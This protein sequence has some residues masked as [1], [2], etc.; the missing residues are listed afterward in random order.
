MAGEKRPWEAFRRPG[1]EKLTVPQM[2]VY[3]ILRG[4]AES[5][6]NLLALAFY[7]HEITYRA[8]WV[9]VCRMA[10]AL[11]TLGLQPDD[12]VMLMLPNSPAY[13]VAYYGILR[14][15]G[16][17]TQVN[18]LYVERELQYIA[19]D[20]QA[21]FLIVA[22]ALYDRV[23]R[24]PESTAIEQVIVAE[25]SGAQTDARALRLR[26]LLEASPEV[27]PPSQRTP[28]DTAVLQYTGGTTGLPKGAMLTHRNLVANAWQS[29][30]EA[31]QPG[32]SRVLAIL[33]FFHVF[34]MLVLN[35]SV[36]H[37][38][39]IVLL[40]RFEID[41]V[42]DAIRDHQITDFPGVPTMYVAVLNYPNAE[43]YG[44]G[45]IRSLSAGGAAMP[46]EV[47]ETFVDKFGAEISEGYGLTEA[48][49]ATHA[50]PTHDPT[51]RKPGSIGIPLPFT[52]ARIVDLETGTRTLP[53]GE[54]GELCIQGPQ[55]MQGYWHRPEETRAALRDGWLYT[56]DIARMDED[57]YFY[58]VDRKKDMIIVSGNNVYPRE[59]EEVLYEHPAVLEAAVIGVPDPYKGEVP[60]AFISLRPGARL[61]EEEVLVHLRAQLAPFKLPKAVEF[62]GELPKS[63][64]GKLLRRELAAQERERRNRDE[65]THK[66][67]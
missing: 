23:R 50:N 22:D 57:G 11:L 51:L 3:D 17:V 16:I 63:A 31:P 43:A 2:P 54:V 8:L 66:G 14:A 56:G 60:K 20:S 40:P 5:H 34:G 49:P 15:G 53:P 37:A 9:D 62:R 59:I 1:T 42:M 13:V 10:N 35:I 38:A 41:R 25:L 30:G 44:I 39:R 27:D 4:T 7:E 46:V 67:A 29:G 26:E 64:V 28:E 32:A 21:R 36:K 47:M 24:L 45:S 65:G 12:R 18:P 6:P 55:V 19:T 52:D 33:P 58:I 48:S 61:T